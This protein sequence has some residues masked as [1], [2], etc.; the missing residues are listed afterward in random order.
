MQQQW[1][2]DLFQKGR[3]KTG[4]PFFYTLVL[5]KEV[6]SVATFE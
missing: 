2:L 3:L 4:M 1:L 5:K 6:E